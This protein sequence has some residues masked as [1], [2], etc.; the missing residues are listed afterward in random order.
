M[1]PI[2]FM[3]TALHQLLS[4][5]IKIHENDSVISSNSFECMLIF[6]FAKR[7][8]NKNVH[9]ISTLYVDDLVL[10]D[11]NIGKFCERL[12]EINLNKN[13]QQIFATLLDS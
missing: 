12:N 8:Q 2:Q 10:T 4:Q 1:I 5:G 7:H 6:L 9:K 11:I 3:N 13:D